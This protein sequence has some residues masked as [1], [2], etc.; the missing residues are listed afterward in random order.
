MAANTELV[1]AQRMAT[2]KNASRETGLPKTVIRKLVEE[3]LVTG[4]KIDSW[5]YINMNSLH[6]YL[7]EMHMEK[8]S[9]KSH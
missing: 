5:T 4:F 1:E 6:S 3:N 9:R 7:K 8:K 2:V